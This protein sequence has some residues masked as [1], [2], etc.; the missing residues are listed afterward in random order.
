MKLVMT[1]S[2]KKTVGRVDPSSSE[3]RRH[4]TC[5]QTLKLLTRFMV[6]FALAYV[7]LS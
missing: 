5:Q 2:L 4:L 1:E 3:A 7:N 6:V